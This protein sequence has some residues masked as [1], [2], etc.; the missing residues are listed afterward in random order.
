M[1]D[2]QGFVTATL[3]EGASGSAV[4]EAPGEAM[5]RLRELLEW[6]LRKDGELSDPDFHDG[7]L[8][9][10]RVEVR[11]EYG[12]GADGGK[13]YPC[14]E[15]L[16]VRVPVVMGKRTGGMPVCLAPTAG[17]RF[18][19]SDPATVRALAVEGVR[20][21]LQGL[22][23]RDLARRIPAG[24]ASLDE[25]V[26][27][28]P[29]EF[30][31]KAGEAR[32]PTLE[33]VADPLGRRGLRAR[34]S[35]AWERDAEVADL[36]A[37]LA[38][39]KANVLIVGEPGC[40]KTAV[41]V[42]AVRRV[43]RGLPIPK[44]AGTNGRAEEQEPDEDDGPSARR[45]FWL[46]SGQRLIAGMMYLGEWQERCERVVEELGR[47]DGCLCVENL[48]DLV[49]AGATGGV[50]GS[51]GSPGEPGRVADGVGAFLL[52]Y[53]QR[54]E[55]R[56]VAEA[57]PAELDAC[58]RVLP[59]LADVMQVLRLE[60]MPRPK[61]VAALD[62]VAAA[63]GNAV[64]R[65]AERG[66]IETVHRLFARFQ[67][68]QA[69]P[70]PAAAFVQDL[71]ERKAKAPPGEPVAVPDALDLFVRRTGLPELFLRDDLP[72]RRAE[73]VE[74]F[75]RQV[76]GQEAACRAAADLVTTFKAGL[77][78]PARPAGVMLFCGPTGVG[79]TELAR[80]LARY[81][82]GQGDDGAAASV[83]S[84][85][86]A[87]AERERLIRLD[88][89]EYS[90]PGSAAR[91][92]GAPDGGP[93]ELI[94][95]MRRRPFSVVLLDEI[96]KADA[97]VFDVLLNVLDEGRLTDR[98]GRLTTFRSAVIIMTSNLGAAA[99][100]AG[101]LGFGAEPTPD[102][103][104]AARDFFRPEF[105]NRI[106]G[107]VSFRPLGRDDIRAITEK[108]LRGIAAREGLS[109]AGVRLEWDAAL[110]EHL[111]RK[112][113]DR[114]YGARP[115]QRTLE[116]LVVTPVSRLMVESPPPRGATIR[117]T[118]SAEGAVTPTVG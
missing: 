79:K 68:Y 75:R 6:A 27:R 32:F 37:R 23:P 82:F 50:G 108:E 99:S 65:E 47:F 11:P 42:D 34:L 19:S 51:G 95:R 104:A 4:A 20:R 41:L 103:E 97:E 16:R 111:S 107:V 109:A 117:L 66:V 81:L 87:V 102:Y 14:P 70:G 1:E 114:R 44:P 25:V 98:F 96:E 116:T 89:S 30:K 28:L 52:P 92:L 53:L 72:L 22:S 74:T 17:V 55:L 39:E 40:G 63:A 69:F 83:A 112:G 100:S 21:A 8:T 49:E 110:V 38:R 46:T 78:D 18:E 94:K 35:R 5:A 12:D 85:R 56:L 13:R 15:T 36:A 91:L 59:A 24:K 7:E 62:R 80:A 88:M 101:S 10:L 84:D 2:P 3:L 31:A 77:N 54:G 67:P 60:P 48:L 113:F 26:I 33:A 106:D 58:R 57:T 93:S 29:R 61:A 90:G 73:V 71:F 9:E 43:E 76:I 115:L 105:F 118:L 86:A 45:R 64:R